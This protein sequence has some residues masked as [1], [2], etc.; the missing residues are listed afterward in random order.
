[1]TW[2][3]HP[4]A[5]VVTR[6]TAHH[7]ILRRICL[8]TGWNPA[9]EHLLPDIAAALKTAGKPLCVTLHPQ[10]PETAARLLE[11]GVDQI[12]LGLDAPQE[13]TYHRHKR[14][15]WELACRGVAELLKRFPGRIEIHLIWGLGDSE[16]SFISAMDAIYRNGGKVALFALT[17]PAG[18]PEDLKAPSVSSYRRIQLF[19]HLREV[20]RLEFADCRFVDEK[21]SGFADNA[22]VRADL[23]DGNA[24]RTSG[25]G[26]CNRPFY[27][28]TPRG[29]WYNFPRP[30]QSAETSAAIVETGLFPAKI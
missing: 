26:D 8:Q 5:E 13:N 21:L 24:F 29:P 9:S 18:S 3:E 2:P 17:P 14:R 6:L 30:L 7:G 15:S 20:G 4:F 23:Q 1:V 25:C 22:A 19:R 16:E 10:Q 28:E 27:N 12:G 11:A